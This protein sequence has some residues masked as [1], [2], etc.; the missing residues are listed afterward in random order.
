[1]LQIKPSNNAQLLAILNREVQEWHHNTYP[2]QFK[3]YNETGIH[4][5]FQ[6]LLELPNWFAFAA[7]WDNEP[8]G[9]TFSFIREQPDS[10]F[11]YKSNI[12]VLDQI[13]VK[14]SFRRKGIACALLESAKNEALK[15]GIMLLEMNHWTENDLARNFFT[16]QGFQYF[17]ERMRLKL[18]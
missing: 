15:K 1:M 14:A 7:W 4:E 16:N 5:A 13:C 11:T 18:S 3:A 2:Q 17:N 9:Y 6:E 12:W 10:A 8:V